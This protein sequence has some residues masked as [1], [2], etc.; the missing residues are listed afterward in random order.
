[1]AKRKKAP[2]WFAWTP[3]GTLCLETGAPTRAGCI[4]KLRDVAAHMPYRDWKDMEKR[5]Y[6][7]ERVGGGLRP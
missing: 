7:V 1:M 2:W 3:G 5:G 4:S 6:T